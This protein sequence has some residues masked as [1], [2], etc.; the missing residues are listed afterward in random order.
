MNRSP[1]ESQPDQKLASWIR[2][3]SYEVLPTRKAIDRLADIPASHDIR[4]TCRPGGIKD[5]LDFVENATSI[6][7]RRVIPHL[8]ARRILGPEHLTSTLD[9]LVKNNIK[10][11]FVMAG[12]G[13]PQSSEFTQTSDI[14]R[15]IVEYGSPFDQI[16]IAGYPEGNPVYHDDATEIL[17]RK[18]EYAA[19]NRLNLEIVTQMC[20]EADTLVGWLADIRARGV[21]LPVRVGTVGRLSPDSMLKVIQAIGFKDSIAFLKSK[22]GLATTIAGNSAIGYQPKE[23]LSKLALADT[24]NGNLRVSGLSLFTL[25]NISGNLDYF[26]N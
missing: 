9:L 22:P 5:T 21:E 11:V 19:K 18:Q 1:L 24:P 20:F 16:G 17:L 4:V 23:F 13:E 25:G 15:R 6:D 14:L 26:R 3:M 2:Q 12:D 10:K 7:Q 8:A